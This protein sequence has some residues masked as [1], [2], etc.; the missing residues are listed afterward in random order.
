MKQRLVMG[1]P[2]HTEINMIKINRTQT[3]SGLRWRNHC[4]CERDKADKSI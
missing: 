1:K 4:R 3:N 2:L